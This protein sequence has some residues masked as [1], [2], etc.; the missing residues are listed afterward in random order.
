HQ[1]LIKYLFY[2]PILESYYFNNLEMLDKW[3]LLLIKLVNK[4]EKIIFINNYKISKNNN[5]YYEILLF[6]L[7]YGKTECF[8]INKDFINSKEYKAIINIKNNTG[9]DL[10]SNI[11]VLHNKNSKNTYSID[12]AIKWL[13]KESCRNLIIQRY[14]GLGEMNANQLWTTT[15]DPNKRCILQITINDINKANNLF[16]ILMGDNVTLRKD[17]IEQNSL[18]AINIDV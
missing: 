12:E 11:H 18:E 17:F 16:N 2:Q 14:K 15:M 8:I 4:N 6:I 7:V 9:I 1:Y 5:L 10:N 3:V 13:L